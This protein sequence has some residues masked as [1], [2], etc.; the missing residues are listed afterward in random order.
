MNILI[1]ALP[2]AVLIDDREVPINTDFRDCLRV[3][4]AFED[5]ELTPTERALVLLSNL[6]PE[7]PSNAEA[8]FRQGVK[9]LNVGEAATDE[10]ATVATDRLYSF[11]QDANLIFAA[12]RQTHGIDLEAIGT[13]HW[14]KFTALFMDLGADTA[15]CQ[16][17]GFRKR[18]FSGKASKEEMSAYRQ[19]RDLVD[20]P[21][22]DTRTPEERRR[23]EEFLQIVM[24]NKE[25]KRAERQAQKEAG[26]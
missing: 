22:P 17:V 19:M 9:F 13:L 20:L 25:R 21:E 26:S 23:E 1:D 11:T 5:E 10:N 2:V 8:A 6:Y 16:L 12:F 24:A 4:L 7:P 15:F 18:V 14:W 3:I